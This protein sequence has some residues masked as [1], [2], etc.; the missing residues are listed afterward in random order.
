MPR[1]VTHL[2]LV[3]DFHRTPAERWIAA[4][5]REAP[6][7]IVTGDRMPLPR[8]SVVPTSAESWVRAVRRQPAAA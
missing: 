5:R 6:V 7:Q 4:V 8:L 2:Q 1:T 3:P